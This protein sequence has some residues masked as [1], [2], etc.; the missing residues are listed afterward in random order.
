MC[1]VVGSAEFSVNSNDF[2]RF[3]VGRL[4]F[5][6]R[7]KRFGK[8][9]SRTLLGRKNREKFQLCVKDLLELKR[10]SRKVDGTFINRRKEEDKKKSKNSNTSKKDKKKKFKKGGSH[11]SMIVSSGYFVKNYVRWA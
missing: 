3:P 9:V 6:L 10:V 5:G 4:V 11:S 8:T 7:C 2:W 1:K